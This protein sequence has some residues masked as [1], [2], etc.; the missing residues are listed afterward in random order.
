LFIERAQAVKPDF[1]LTND[2]ASAVAEICLRLDG[3]PLAIELAT[4]RISLFS[5]QALL[6]RL[7]SRL[8][9]L[10]GGVRGGRSGG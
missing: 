3:L 2:T 4:A 6:E 10:R 5:P 1:E 7:G 8:K 9:L